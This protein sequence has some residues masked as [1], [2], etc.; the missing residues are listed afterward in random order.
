MIDQFSGDE[1][2][3]SLQCVFLPAL[4]FSAVTAGAKSALGR[5][6]IAAAG[7]GEVLFN[8]KARCAMCHVPPLFTEPSW[9]LHKADVIGIDDFQAKRTRMTAM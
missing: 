4:H 7:R 9:N 8:G 5:I 6:D 1:G 2:S 3:R